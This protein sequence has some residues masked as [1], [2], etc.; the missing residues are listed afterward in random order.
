MK[1]MVF[2]DLPNRYIFHDSPKLFFINIMLWIKATFRSR[3]NKLIDRNLVLITEMRRVLAGEI[4]VEKGKKPVKPQDLVRL[5]E[6]IIQ[7]VFT[8]TFIRHL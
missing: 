3:C 8:F 6:S 4:V 1:N 7:V 5:F 2:Q